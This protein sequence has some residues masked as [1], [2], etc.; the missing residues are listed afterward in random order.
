MFDDDLHAKRTES[1]ASATVGAVQA[2]KLGVAA[3]GHGLAIAKGLEVKHAIKQV[4]RLFSNAG[5][6]IWQLFA[7]WV[8]YLVGS[9]PEIVVALDWTDFDKDNQSTIALNMITSH[10][11]AT[12]LMWLT[13]VKSELLGW[14]NEYED[15]LLVR[16]REV[17]PEGVKATVLADRGFGDQKLYALMAEL[18]LDYAIR[19]KENIQVTSDGVSK[20]ASEWV[21]SNGRPR[22]LRDASVTGDQFNVPAVVCVK[23]SGMKDAWCLATSRADLLGAAIVKLYGKRFTIE[24]N[25]RD[26]KDIHFGMGLSLIRISKPERRDRILLVSALTVVLL[27]VL[28]AAGESLGMDR[29][30]K[31]NTVKTR[32]HSVFRQGC[33]L[34]DLLPNMPSQR[35]RPLLQRFG[36][37]MLEQTLYRQAFGWI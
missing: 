10:G 14:R 6:D 32:T 20:P 18:N 21:P 11:R 3:I 26:T 1:L 27:T 5:L 37:M 7:C 9:R 24:E 36:K 23:A 34:Y 19:F 35:K 17:L 8:P 16:L 25:F 2:A 15:R 30:L 12:P 29:M 31:A 28:G 22:L 33:M 4:D 13:V